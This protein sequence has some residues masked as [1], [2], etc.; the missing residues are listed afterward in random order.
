VIEVFRKCKKL[1]Q[2][3]IVED[4]LEYGGISRP[5]IEALAGLPRLETL[6][7]GWVKDVQ[8]IDLE[9]LQSATC[10]TEIGTYGCP[11]IRKSAVMELLPGLVSVNLDEEED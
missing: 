2:V 10:L 8:V 6:Y 9:L 7:L 4:V 11:Q 5:C 1:Q 3:L